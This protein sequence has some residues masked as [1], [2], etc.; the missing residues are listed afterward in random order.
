VFGTPCLSPRRGKGR[1]SGGAGELCPSF[2]YGGGTEGIITALGPPAFVHLNLQRRRATH[3][4]IHTPSRRSRLAITGNPFVQPEITL[5]QNRHPSLRYIRRRQPL[6]GR[7]RE[8]GFIMGTTSSASGIRST[9]LCLC[10]PPTTLAYILSDW[11]AL[12]LFGHHTSNSV[13]ERTIRSPPIPPLPIPPHIIHNRPQHI[14]IQMVHR[15][16]RVH[17]LNL[18]EI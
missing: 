5:S 10:G 15:R 3:R 18:S 4:V 14:P 8:G 16:E 17:H 9:P 11:F 2:G 13:I 1:W 6:L 12:F 7:T